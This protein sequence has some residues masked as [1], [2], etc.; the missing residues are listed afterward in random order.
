MMGY[1]KSGRDGGMPAALSLG[2]V[3][4]VGLRLE[5][6]AFARQAL[7]VC[8]GPQAGSE[9]GEMCG[10]HRRQFSDVGGADPST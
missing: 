8:Q 4:D 9:P 6:T 5:V 1:A 3:V 10:A 2:A 7:E